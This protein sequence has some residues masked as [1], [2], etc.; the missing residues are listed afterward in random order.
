MLT[1]KAMQSEIIADLNELCEWTIERLAAHHERIA[2][3]EAASKPAEPTQRQL[4]LTEHAE[5]MNKWG[6]ES[7]IVAQFVRSHSDDQEFVRL[8]E[9]ARSLKTT[10]AEPTPDVEKCRHCGGTGRIEDVPPGSSHT[11]WACFESWG[12][13]AKGVA[14]PDVEKA[15]LAYAHSEWPGREDK[16]VVIRRFADAVL[17]GVRWRDEHPKPAEPRKT[18]PGEGS[19]EWA[20]KLTA[21]PQGISMTVPTQ[22]ANT[23]MVCTQCGAKI[24]SGI[25]VVGPA[26]GIFCNQFCAES[27]AKR[28]PAEPVPV[29]QG[30]VAGDAKPIAERL[31]NI[32]RL[33]DEILHAAGRPVGNL[34]RHGTALRYIE[35][36][37]APKTPS[38]DAQKAAREYAA[39]ECGARYGDIFGYL[40]T[41][42]L[43]GHTAGVAE[44]AVEME[45]LRQ[46]NE[47]LL[48]DFKAVQ[49]RQ[50]AYDRVYKAIADLPIEPAIAGDAPDG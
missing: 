50:F 39:N 47:A 26:A 38:V 31:A 17:Y 14:E 9:T 20:E 2:A 25:G 23:S 15:A 34:S 13:K 46:D 5:L 27:Y 24:T 33:Y 18:I 45:R 36:A 48:R 40:V 16:S 10:F 43:A 32:E 12:K 11:C 42:Y 29:D 30:Q 41:G 21:E 19:S 44:A 37:V 22:P 1:D 28:K 7:I 35:E 4:W 3:L 49:M 8:A 6:A